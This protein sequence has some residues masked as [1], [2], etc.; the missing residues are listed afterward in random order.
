MQFLNLLLLICFTIHKFDVKSGGFL[1]L[2]IFES[3]NLTFF[4]RVLIFF[5][6]LKWMSECLKGGLEKLKGQDS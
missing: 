5:I 6:L 2:R 4:P 1:F 3:Q